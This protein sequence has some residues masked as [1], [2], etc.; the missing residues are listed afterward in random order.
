MVIARSCLAR[1]DTDIV[2]LAFFASAYFR[3]LQ[4]H[5][6][7]RAS[8][9]PWARGFSK[10]FAMLPGCCNHYGWEPELERFPIGGSPV[11]AEMGK[12]VDM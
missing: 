6:G 5:L 3:H 2:A 9:G 10:A 12:K 1:Y 4:W 8:Q 7:L 11:H